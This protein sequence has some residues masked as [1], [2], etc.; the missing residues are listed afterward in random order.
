MNFINFFEDMWQAKPTRVDR[1]S[2]LEVNKDYLRIDADVLMAA[3][4]LGVRVFGSDTQRAYFGVGSSFAFRY[5]TFSGRFR[6]YEIENDSYIVG[7]ISGFPLHETVPLRFRGIRKDDLRAIANGYPPFYRQTFTAHSGVEIDHP[8]RTMRDIHRA[9][10][11]AAIGFS[12]DLPV[13]V[14]N[15]RYKSAY[16]EACD[17]VRQMLKRLQSE[18]SANAVYSPLLE[19]AVRAVRMMN[20]NSSG[21]G[22]PSIVHGTVFQHCDDGRDIG[23]NLNA[24]QLRFALKLFN[25]Y[26]EGSLSADERDRLEPILEEILKATVNGIYTWWQ[27]LNNDSS[28]LPGWLLDERIRQTPIWVENGDNIEVE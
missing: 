28:P 7:Q 18:Y 6:R 10:W 3:I 22:L 16:Q 2:Y 12:S 19:V 21:S 9:G 27:Y 24:A 20:Q 4:F 14:Y 11:V 8:V 5:G 15:A 17:R 13:H 1:P 26:S 23:T 25:D